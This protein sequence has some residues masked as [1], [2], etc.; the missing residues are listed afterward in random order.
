MQFI[1]FLFSGGISVS[2]HLFNEESQKYFVRGMS[3]SGTG[4]SPFSYLTGNH[5]ELVRKFKNSKYPSYPSGDTVEG[6]IDFMRSRTEAQILEFSR[7][8]FDQPNEVFSVVFW[9]I[10]ESTCII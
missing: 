10:V 9:P 5:V 4:N 3:A 2:L 8:I 1:S 6:L 7:E